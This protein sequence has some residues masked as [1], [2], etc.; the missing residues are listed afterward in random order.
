LLDDFNRPNNSGPP[1]PNWTPMPISNTISSNTLYISGSQVTGYANSNGD[2]WNTQFGPDSEVWLTVATKPTADLD[3]VT[4]GLRFQNPGLASASG[5]QAYFINRSAGP[6]QYRI[7]VRGSNG[8][9][10]ILASATGPEL[11][12]GDKLLFRAVGSHLQ[13]W[14]FD[15]GSWSLLLNATDSTYAGSGYLCISSRNSVVRLDDFGG[16]TIK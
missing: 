2:Y 7:Q 13:F 16:G 9:A 11:N 5:Y 14:R 15:A 4:L 8:V 1:G 12:P 3:P 10:T 6:D